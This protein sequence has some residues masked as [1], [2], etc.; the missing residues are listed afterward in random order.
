MGL[1]NHNFGGLYCHTLS[2]TTLC[3]SDISS[4]IECIKPWMDQLPFPGTLQSNLSN[5]TTMISSLLPLLGASMGNLTLLYDHTTIATNG[6]VPAV[7][8][9]QSTF[10]QL[11]QQES[12]FASAAASMTPGRVNITA[13]RLARDML[14]ALLTVPTSWENKTQ[15]VQATAEALQ[16]M[17]SAIVAVDDTL[18][19]ALQQAQQLLSGPASTLNSILAYQTASY[20]NIRPCMLSLENRMQTINDTVM[21][22]PALIDQNLQLLKATEEKLDAVL[23]IESTTA[24]DQ[25]ASHRL[26][27]S[28]SQAQQELSSVQQLVH[29][30]HEVRQ[31]LTANAASI[32]NAIASLNSMQTS[33]AASTQNLYTL[34]NELNAYMNNQAT[35]PPYIL[36]ATQTQAAG[37]LVNTQASALT[38][39]LASTAPIYEQ[40]QHMLSYMSTNSSLVSDFVVKINSLPNTT[41]LLESVNRYATVYASLPS[42]PSLVLDDFAASLLAVVNQIASTIVDARSSLSS[43]IGNANSS[44][45]SIRHKSVDKIQAYEEEYL[46]TAQH[47]D[48]MYVVVFSLMW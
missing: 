38:S 48:R 44:L 32:D 19:T 34:L 6:A 36:L 22:L 45:A 30:L 11:Q 40:A 13:S 25:T 12:S 33:M 20:I 10:T 29:S 21:E 46:P 26:S 28:L 37:A 18:S 35:A 5:A 1:N 16:T 8:A 3:Q 7:L 47:I 15:M 42:P 14:S 2:Y 23:Q 4:S 41:D 9:S 27:S 31:N 17:K 43:T 39:W 24:T